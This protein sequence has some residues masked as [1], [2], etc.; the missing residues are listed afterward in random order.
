MRTISLIL[1]LAGSV[2]ACENDP[3]C[4]CHLYNFTSKMESEGLDEIFHESDRELSVDTEKN[5][6]EILKM[7]T[8]DEPDLSPYL[9][10]EPEPVFYDL[11]SPGILQKR[12]V[13]SKPTQIEQAASQPEA[14]SLKTSRVVPKN[15]GE[16]RLRSPGNSGLGNGIDPPPASFERARPKGEALGLKSEND[17]QPAVKQSVL[18]K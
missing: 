14:V 12:S 1:L 6:Q 4:L 17:S 10:V 2:W 15:G 3:L 11:P 7:M 16:P 8:S 9:R 13:D 18:Q 5:L